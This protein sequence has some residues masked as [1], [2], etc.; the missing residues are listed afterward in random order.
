MAERL[1]TVG[2]LGAG[3]MGAGIA[4]VAACGGWRVK[5]KDVDLAIALRAM[6]GVKAQLG[7]LVEKGRMTAASAAEAASRISPSVN[8]SE[9]ID[10]DLVIEAIVEDLAVK[11]HVLRESLK[12]V[13][14]ECIIA[15]NTS[16]L[17]IT[18][19]GRAIGQSQ[20]TIG[21]HF[22]NPAPVMQ[23]VEVIAGKETDP[24][25]VDRVA[26]TAESWGKKV[27]RAADVP[28]FIVNHVARPYYLEAFR[29]LETGVAGPVEIDE[30]MK[31]LG[32]FKM[33]PFELTD[34]IGHDVNAATTRNVWEQLG[35][36]ELLMP[37]KSQEKLVELG[38]LGRK[39][40]RGVYDY[41]VN[42]P[43]PVAPIA[44][45]MRQELP[46]SARTALEGFV[47]AATPGASMP[48][49]DDR[50]PF[51]FARILAA[52]I[53][54]AHIAN[55]RGVASRRDIDTAMKYGVNYPKGPFEWAEQ[56]GARQIVQWLHAL[57]RF[58]VPRSLGK[59][60]GGT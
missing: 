5:L 38:L 51:V 27:A 58:G 30:A 12:H 34:F 6:D 42:P 2:V 35:R 52:V 45:P 29:I 1:N 40:G 24:S 48:A 60:E 44:S 49:G 47:K 33:G 4:Q 15:T 10:C 28:G 22:F 57:N 55:E 26:A 16:S 36:P 23:L 17:S 18:A 53:V 13:G 21:M 46:V 31:T 56:I 54:Q 9:L 3:T 7:K 41:S 20:R 43:Q 19:I 50:S 37:S 59:P 39:S 14:A 11:A 25:V 32:G 8:D